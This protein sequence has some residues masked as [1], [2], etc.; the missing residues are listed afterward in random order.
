MTSSPRATTDL[1]VTPFTPTV[2]RGRALR[3]YGVI[4]ALAR[5]RD[6]EVV[7]KRFGD[8]QPAQEYANLHRVVLAGVTPSKNAGRALLYL[9]ARL[10]GVPDAE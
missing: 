6:V 7:Y 3:T 5:H 1:V 9:R 8:A 4:A 2:D 10:R